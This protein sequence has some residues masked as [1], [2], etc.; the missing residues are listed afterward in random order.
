M[1]QSFFIGALG[2]H[3]QQK[4]L[5]VTSN[6]IANVNAHGFKAGKSRFVQ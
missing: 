5:A 4:S 6:N 2:A 1:N 3:Q